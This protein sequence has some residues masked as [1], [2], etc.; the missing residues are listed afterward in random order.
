MYRNSEV[1]LND[2]ETYELPF[3]GKLSPENRW[4]IM[5]NLIPWEKFEKEYAK[6]F[7]EKKG[8]PALPFR[9]ALGALIIQEKLGISDRETV[10]Q[11]KE[12]PYLQYFIGLTSYQKE[13]PFD[14][15]MMV[16]F[17]KRIKFKIVNKIN[18]E[19][20]KKG[21]E[22]LESSEVEEIPETQEEE[23][24]KK[25]QG[26]L[27][28]DATCA[29]ADIKYPTDLDILNQ[30][31]KGTEKILDR[32]YQEVKEKWMKKPR[33]YRNKAR[34]NYLKVAKK[35]RP[36]QKER[37]KAI[38]QQ[39][40][41]IKR[42][43][44]YIDQVIEQGASLSCLSKRQYKQ[45]LVIQ[46]IYRQQQEMWTEKKQRVDQR[47]VSL[48]QPHVRP[49]V[50]G[51]A[52]K[53]T[54]FGAKLS[55][56]YINEF[57]FL[58]RLS[59]ENF[60]ESKDLIPQIENFKNTYGCYPES[61]H[62]DQIYR[63]RENRKW[64]QERGI[65]LSG[66][67]LGRPPKNRSAELKKQAQ[68]DEKF[69]NRIEGKFGQAKR[70]FGLDRVMTKLSETSENKIA[71]TFLVVNLFTLL[72]RVLLSLFVKNQKS[73]LFRSFLSV[74]FMLIENYQQDN[75]LVKEQNFLLAS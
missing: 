32:L 48:N 47:I 38:G 60:N 75:L 73:Y 2:P 26:K 20:V 33:T 43:L 39:L 69:R 31:R 53:P 62:V 13:D 71:I 65:R 23:G 27:I 34:K 1:P 12:N 36:S 64:C 30:A 18:Q 68:L 3:E 22:I 35:R 6:N 59:W 4:V 44:G 8:A 11:I 51:K 61:V 29:P 74:I 72:R 17:R 7:S 15:S 14:P 41:Y 19:M 67:P 37:R 70:C 25:N 66:L 10:E 28:L 24:E 50:R 54:E 42:N 55:V 9:I 5:A 45:L 63:T 16:Y 52:G 57:V 40:G 46:E 58:D 49:I 21:R 56:S